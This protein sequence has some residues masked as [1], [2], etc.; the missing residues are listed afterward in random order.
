[1][2]GG[3][4]RRGGARLVVRRRALAGSAAGAAGAAASAVTFHLALLAIPCAIT[5]YSLTVTFIFNRYSI[6]EHSIAFDKLDHLYIM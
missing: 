5:L 1:M 4:A 3:Q 2:Y 6:L